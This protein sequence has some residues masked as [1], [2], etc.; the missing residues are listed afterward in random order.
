[1]K[2]QK[3][4]KIVG[5]GVLSAI[6]TVLMFIEFPLPGFPPFL[7]LDIS[8]LPVLIGAF[9]YGPV[10]GICIA[11]V[12][13]LIHLFNTSSMGVGELADFLV[14]A[15]YALTAGLIYRKKKTRKNAIMGIII[16]IIVSTIVGCITNYYILLPFYSFAYAMPIEQ[17]VS[18]TPLIHSVW[19]YILYAVMPFNLI[20]GA[21]VGGITIAIY[22]KISFRI[23]GATL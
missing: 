11:L 9:I 6:S 13:N 21:L 14:V 18:V 22:K 15:S 20:K 19:E 12:K 23:K 2:T 4:Q 3:T 10:S 5:I 1:M 17:I 8:N 16:G 7:K